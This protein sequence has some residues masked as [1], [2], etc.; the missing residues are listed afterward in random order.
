[1]KLPL[2]FLFLSASA[3]PLSVP[4]RASAQLSEDAQEDAPH[5]VRLTEL[6][7]AAR[8]ADFVASGA[9]LSVAGVRASSLT[10]RG[11][12][13]DDRTLGV[14]FSS[15]TEGYAQDG[16]VSVHRLQYASLGGGSGGLEGELGGLIEGGARIPL[17]GRHGVVVRGGV[18]AYLGGNDTLYSSLLELPRG[19]VVYQLLSRRVLL[20]AGAQGGLVLLGRYDA[21]DD[22]GRALGVSFDWGAYLALQHAPVRLNAGLMRIEA[23]STGSGRPVDILG[24]T[25]CTYAGK[26]ALCTDARYLRGDLGGPEGARHEGAESFYLGFMIGLA[27]VSF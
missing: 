15:R 1:V 23:R 25:L 21:G 22:A 24:G 9:R 19:A 3:L 14:V 5:S 10:V 11:S 8:A 4:G 2:Y 18:Q 16:W 20:E 26:L 6:E 27:S 12:D 7:A 13:A 17:G